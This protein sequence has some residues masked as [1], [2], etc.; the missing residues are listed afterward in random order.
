MVKNASAYPTDALATEVAEILSEALTTSNKNTEKKLARL[1]LL[2]DI[3]HN[4]SSM[5]KNASAYPA[6][7]KKSL[8]EIV[9]T[10]HDLSNILKNAEKTIFD[11]K[12]LKLCDLWDKHNFYT[13]PFINRLRNAFLGR[14]PDE[15]G[16]KVLSI[17]KPPP[18]PSTDPEVDGD[19]MSSGSDVDGDPMSDIDGEAMSDSDDP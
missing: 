10:L 7:F 17:V 5:V 13:K 19:P 15:R 4:S 16:F 18:A 12:I 1:Y 11:K 14:K 8:P 6:E 2:H 3:L 9:K